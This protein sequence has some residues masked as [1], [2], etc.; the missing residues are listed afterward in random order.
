MILVIYHNSSGSS[1]NNRQKYQ[2]T[3]YKNDGTTATVSV[4]VPGTNEGAGTAVTIVQHEKFLGD[5]A[6]S[7][8][9]NA[10]N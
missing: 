10:A 2:I 9:T 7:G 4:T 1:T 6:L 5:I 8:T 3:N